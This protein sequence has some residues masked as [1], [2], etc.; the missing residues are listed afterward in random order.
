[1][2]RLF[3]LF[4]F[5]LAVGWQSPVQACSVC[6]KSQ[7]KQAESGKLVKATAPLEAIVEV[8]KSRGVIGMTELFVFR[9]EKYPPSAYSVQ[10]FRCFRITRGIQASTW[11]NAKVR[12]T[13]SVPS[14]SQV[15]L[16]HDY[17]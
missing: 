8:E 15:D 6:I 5:V 9:P 1:M 14:L 17:G 10:E 2:K 4:A 16:H 12:T 13:P 3:L 7:T 11:A